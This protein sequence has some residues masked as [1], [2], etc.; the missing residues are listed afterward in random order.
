MVLNIL[1]ASGSG[2][3]DGGLTDI[4][5]RACDMLRAEGIAHDDHRRLELSSTCNIKCM[6]YC[7][8]YR[9]D[10]VTLLRRRRCFFD[11][12]YRNS[13]TYDDSIDCLE[14]GS[15]IDPKVKISVPSEVPVQGISIVFVS[16][17]LCM[18]VSQYCRC[19]SATTT[20]GCRPE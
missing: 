11:D 6:V 5:K 15:R 1:R 10:G 16:F 18:T 3:E 8:Q 19:R 2:G 13:K 20:Y 17:I 12:R 14:K 4:L 7:G 9:R